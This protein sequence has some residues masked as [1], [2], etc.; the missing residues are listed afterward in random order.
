MSAKYTDR[1]SICSTHSRCEKRRTLHRHVQM[2][3][4]WTMYNHPLGD[5]R[6]HVDD[7][8]DPKKI[9]RNQPYSRNKPSW[10]AVICTGLRSWRSPHGRSSTRLSS[11]FKVDFVSC[12]A[13]ITVWTL[14][15]TDR[16]RCNSHFTHPGA[17]SA[18]FLSCRTTTDFLYIEHT[19]TPGQQNQILPSNKPLGNAG[20]SRVKD[21]I[22]WLSVRLHSCIHRGF[23][24]QG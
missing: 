2:R 23:K 16:H 10:P 15:S 6:S 22:I 9:T 18:S 5:K 14:S 4:E 17:L 3:A 20:R 1:H 13:H 7:I 12:A 8:D 19:P 24:N 11:K 21:R